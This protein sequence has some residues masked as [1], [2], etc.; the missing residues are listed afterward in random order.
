MTL[1][2][3]NN[4]SVSMAFVLPSNLLDFQVKRQYSKDSGKQGIHETFLIG[5]E[6]A[7]RLYGC[8]MTGTHFGVLPGPILVSCFV[9]MY[10]YHYSTQPLQM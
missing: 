6:R 10:K 9:V 5:D 8:V 1:F 3:T 7:Y 4:F 2:V